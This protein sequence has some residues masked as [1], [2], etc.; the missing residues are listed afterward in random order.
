MLMWLCGV[1]ELKWLSVVLVMVGKMLST[2][3]FNIVFLYS[4]ELI[5]TELRTQGMSAGMMSSRAGAIVAP[6]IMSALVSG[7]SVVLA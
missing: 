3:A 6:F 1:S 7:S 2:A 4:L 5:P